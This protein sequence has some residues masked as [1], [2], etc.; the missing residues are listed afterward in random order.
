MLGC[1]ISP[2]F[3]SQEKELF[4]MKRQ[5]STIGVASS[6]VLIMCFSILALS[7]IGIWAD[8][9]LW[10]VRAAEWLLEAPRQYA[11]F[12]KPLFSVV[13]YL[14]SL[15]RQALGV[16]PMTPPRL[17]FG[18]LSIASVYMTYQVVYQLTQAR[19]RAALAA[20]LLVTS[21]LWIYRSFRI[22]SD[23]LATFFVMFCLL[24]VV[25]EFQKDRVV[26]SLIWSFFIPLAAFITPK[27]IYLAIAFLPL[28]TLLFVQWL[29]SKKHRTPVHRKVGLFL[30]IA[31]LAGIVAATSSIWIDS[32]SQAFD[33][34]KKTFRGRDAGVAYM[35]L[36]SFGFMLMFLQKN[37]LFAG[38]VAVGILHLLIGVFRKRRTLL[39]QGLTAASL[40]MVGVWIFHPM[41]L[42]FFICSY[43]PFFALIVGVGFPQIKGSA[44]TFLA[45]VLTL[46]LSLQ[47]AFWATWLA[48]DYSNREQKAV[49][50]SLQEY[51]ADVSP[52]EIYDLLG[53]LPEKK[54]SSLY[55]GPGQGAMNFWVLD[56]LRDR[57]YK[58]ILYV[59]KMLA[60]EPQ[61]S[62]F[63]RQNYA[64]IG[65]GVYKRMEVIEGLSE[66]ML[67]SW[68]QLL[69]ALQCVESC[70]KGNQFLVV[71]GYDEKMNVMRLSLEEPGEEP[72]VLP[73]YVS[74]YV[75][76]N[77]GQIRVPPSIKQVKG[78]SYR[79][80]DGW[81]TTKKLRELFQFDLG[82]H[83]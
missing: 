35:S 59:D 63:V 32:Y 70:E 23:L 47:G 40:V 43:L 29:R 30:L 65:Y 6:S 69:T 11:L 55:I 21:S 77:R 24:K 17:L 49:V 3:E 81:P 75:R 42:P 58:Y 56:H 52:D 79:R 18:L 67:I 12:M 50:A 72:K 53:V 27:A 76:I 10:S 74:T 16:L 36:E 61:L 57:Q 19:L 39:E 46:I 60:L 1:G 26:K 2:A 7:Q 20:L 31:G 22:R 15:V 25:I 48:K 5:I 62:D 82:Y 34:F 51:F 4:I 64:H 41:K 9:E 28:Q 14:C 54:V 44:G 33:Y 8:S 45:F 38:G 83:L 37:P 80:L 78:V 73:A 66:S 71:K 68:S 13:L